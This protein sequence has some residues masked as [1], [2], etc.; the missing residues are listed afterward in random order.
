[1]GAVRCSSRVDAFNNMQPDILKSHRV[2]GLRLNFEVNLSMS[3]Y[4]YRIP[5]VPSRKIK[6]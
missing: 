2:L 1:M 6:W 3:Y 4:T 5:L